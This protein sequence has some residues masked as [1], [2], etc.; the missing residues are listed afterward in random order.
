MRIR[1]TLAVLVTAVVL[2]AGCGGDDTSDG[3]RPA[4]EDETTPTATPISTVAAPTPTAEVPE[5]ELDRLTYAV[6]QG[7]T[8]GTIAT[9]FSVPLGALIAVNALD[10]P[11]L[12]GIG[13]E[14]IIPTLDEVADWEAAQQAATPEAPETPAEETGSANN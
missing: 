7:D 3:D 9:E 12:I 1:T 6:E 4:I 13:Q 2:I 5:I 8:L 10:N 14:I 11:N